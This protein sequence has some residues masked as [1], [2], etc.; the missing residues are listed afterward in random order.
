MR[1]RG[2]FLVLCFA[3]GGCMIPPTARGDLHASGGS[4]DDWV[5]APATCRGGFPAFQ[6]LDL[7]GG[8]DDSESMRAGATWVRVA[9]DEASDLTVLRVYAGPSFRTRWRDPREGLDRVRTTDA[10]RVLE[11][12]STNCPALRMAMQVRRMRYGA[13]SSASLHVDCV[14]SDGTRVRGDISAGCM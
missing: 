11:L 1:L 2:V 6:G 4:L 8:D 12:R 7:F 13:L 9:H 5:F 10:H 14:A 3:V